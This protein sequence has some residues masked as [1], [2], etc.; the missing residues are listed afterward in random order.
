MRNHTICAL[1]LQGFPPIGAR[2]ACWQELHGNHHVCK[3]RSVL[4][5][6]QCLSLV[7]VFVF[8]LT[9]S[10]QHQCMC[11]RICLYVFVILNYICTYIKPKVCSY[12]HVSIHQYE[13]VSISVPRCNPFVVVFPS[14]QYESSRLFITN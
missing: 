10:I 13:S 7:R 9:V 6:T 4:Y 3:L 8:R 2:G 14:V 1:I 11:V 5:C 12:T